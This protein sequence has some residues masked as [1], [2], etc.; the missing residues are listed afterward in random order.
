MEQ[1]KE[2]L[3]PLPSIQVDVVE[4]EARS[5]AGWLRCEIG[6]NLQFSTSDL[7]SYCFAQ[8]Q[9]VVFD[10]LLVAAAVE[11]C[12]KIQRRPALSWGREFKLRIPVHDPDRWNRQDVRNA[13]HDALDF[14]TGDRWEITFVGRRQPL[15]PPRQIQFILPDERCAVIP[16]SDGLDSR[17]VA[18]LMALKMGDRLIR[19]RLGSKTY[20]GQAQAGK[21][22]PFTSVPYSISPSERRFQES[23]ARSRGFKFTLISGLA[24]YL[25][26]AGRVVMPESGQGALGPVLVPIGQAYE[27]YRNHPLFTDRMERFLA[28]L[29]DHAIRYEFPQLWNTKGETLAAFVRECPEGS[30]WRETWSCWQQSRQVSVDGRKRQCGICAACML[31]RLSVHAAGLEEAKEAYVWENLRAAEFQAGTASTFERDKITGA[32]REYAIAG[33]LH[34]D[35]LANLR[36]VSGAERTFGLHAFQ[37]GRSLGLTEAD[38]HAKLVGLLSRHEREWK[39]FM[40]SLG[41]HAFATNWAIYGR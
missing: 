13:L 16:F 24:A 26:Q 34:L 28:A 10:A 11:F 14:L 4:G 20:D 22:Q 19:V 30:S 7:E 5:R 15:N 31:R 32:M 6:R 33:T 40:N 35:H 12:D 38:A 27:D 17:A 23:S 18:G 1:P 29:L 9:A 36:Y 37:L 41:P 3:S 25:V 21:R 8:W 2:T 39:S